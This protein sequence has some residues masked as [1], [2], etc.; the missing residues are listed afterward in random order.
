MNKKDLSGK[1]FGRLKVLYKINISDDIKSKKNYFWFCKCN[2]GNTKIA[3]GYSLLSGNLNSCG[4]LH[5]EN[6][7]QLALQ[8][9]CTNKKENEYNLDSDIG[10]G[11]IN[12]NEEFYFDKEDFDKIKLY[13]WNLSKDKYVVYRNRKYGLKLHRLILNISDPKI[14]ID[15][16][17]RNPKNNC[18]TNLRIVTNSENALNSK[19]YS[20]KILGIF[21]REKNNKWE[22]RL[23]KNNKYI[24]LG[25]YSR[26]EDAIVARLNG[27]KQYFGEFAPQKYLF[28]EYGII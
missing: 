25:C 26:I 2:C 9:K 8:L 5:K 4:C 12:N 6:S 14:I 1:T 16:I 22:S 3:N 17:D 18:K 20:N 11:Y 24:Y 23:Y 21:F 13:K 10:I 27:E 19:I 28:K 7:K 15:H